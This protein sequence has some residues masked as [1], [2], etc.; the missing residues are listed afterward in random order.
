[1][2]GRRLDHLSLSLSLAAAHGSPS[3]LIYYSVGGSRE[4]P[5][6]VF[7]HHTVFVEWGIF[8]TIV[9]TVSRQKSR[10]V[11]CTSWWKSPFDWVWRRKS[12]PSLYVVQK[13]NES[14]C[15]NLEIR[16]SGN[17]NPP[18]HP[19][20]KE[21][22]HRRGIS[23]WALCPVGR[24]KSWAGWNIDL[25]LCVPVLHLDIDQFPTSFGSLL[26][27]HQLVLSGDL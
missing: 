8:T 13:L 26:V 15:V 5:V 27:Q 4:G 24:R 21:A 3:H 14:R 7:I 1:V 2:R 17:R 18:P 22:H 19:S 11:D 9:G 20:L 25:F 16:K 23:G 12:K 6:N 10:V